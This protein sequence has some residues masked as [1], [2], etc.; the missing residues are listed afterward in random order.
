[1]HSSTPNLRVIQMIVIKM[2]G[3]VFQKGLSATLSSDIKNIVSHNKIVVVHGGGDEVTKT[4]EKLGKKQIFVTS[5][6]GIR[7]RYTDQETIEIFTMVMAGR[8]NK[9]IVRWLQKNNIE[10]VGLSGIDAALLRAKRKKRLVI[11]D[12]R[13]R[14]RIIEGGF[15]GKVTKVNASLLQLLV[16]NCYVPVVAPIALGEE[17]EFLNVDADR[18]AAQVAGA[19][20]A[21]TVIFL[22]DVPGVQLGG[23]YIEKILMRDVERLLT[24][25]GPGM[26]KKVIASAEA[27]ESGVKEAVIASGFVDE[28]V[29]WALNHTSGTVV[30]YE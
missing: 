1:M 18:A 11:V 4:A 2:G 26:D 6:E 3:D 7:S 15:T 27:L 21:D 8:I 16:D 19:L 10:A 13:N 25:I 20:K 28:P 9:I 5:P 14:K 30:S 17:D 22:T 24:K 23:E 29:S 12:E